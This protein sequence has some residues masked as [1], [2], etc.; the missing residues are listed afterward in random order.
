[1]EKINVAFAADTNYAQHVAVAMAS[2]M[3]NVRSGSAVRFFL[4]SDGIEDALLQRIE[5]TASRFHAELVVIDLSKAEGFE[6]VY[7]SG[8]ISRAAYFRLALPDILPDDVTKVIY[9]DTD[10]LVLD[11]ISKLWGIDLQGMP[12][13]AVPDYGIM[14]SKRSMKEKRKTIGLPE[15]AEYFNSGVLVI[16]L[17]TW[18]ECGY[19][20]QVVD[21]AAKKDLRHHDQD[22]LNQVFIG[23][24]KELPLSWNV[25]PPV[26]QL[27]PKVLRNGKFRKNALAAR[28]S[29]S[30]LH[31][32]GRCKPWDFVRAE[33]FNE[34]YYAYLALTPFAG[35]PM[36][37]PGANSKGKSLFRQRFKIKLADFISSIL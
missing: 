4:L 20:Q 3:K 11:D 9:C 21:V 6:T 26:M 13:A 24:W 29:I 25:I 36:P 19:A 14:A 22:A 15:G 17:S 8:H 34:T 30:I 27:L 16:D 37:K 12:L 5:E 2:V 18:R 32:A 7:T 1:M 23:K 10:L 33:G 31:Y 35:E 28:R